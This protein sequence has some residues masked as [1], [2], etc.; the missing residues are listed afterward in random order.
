[1]LLTDE[2]GV[3]AYLPGLSEYPKQ[4]RR[5]TGVLTFR[6]GKKRRLI[7]CLLLQRDAIASKYRRRL[8]KTTDIATTDERLTIEKWSNT[9]SRVIFQRFDSS[10]LT[11]KS[12]T[13]WLF[14][15]RSE[16]IVLMLDVSNKWLSYRCTNS[17]AFTEIYYYLFIDL[18]IYC[19]TVLLPEIN[20]YFS[21]SK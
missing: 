18:F 2:Y 4:P 10:I 14:F 8:C 17:S 1:M 16:A 13:H 15:F 3:G 12:E 20:I 9:H 11:R 7:S 5:F 6:T 19:W 21:R